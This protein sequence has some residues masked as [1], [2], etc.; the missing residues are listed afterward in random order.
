ME[1]LQYFY[2]KKI[3]KN[4]QKNGDQT[5]HE[6][7]KEEDSKRN[8]VIN[9]F[10]IWEQM[11]LLNK[12]K[13]KLSRENDGWDVISNISKCSSD[14]RKETEKKKILICLGNNNFGQLGFQE[15]SK[16]GIVDFSTVIISKNY[17]TNHRHPRGRVK[18]RVQLGVDDAVMDDAVVDD[19]VMDETFEEAQRLGESCTRRKKYNDIARDMKRRNKSRPVFNR[20]SNNFLSKNEM[21]NNILTRLPNDFN[22]STIKRLKIDEED[23]K[24]K[25]KGSIHNLRENRLI[26]SSSGKKYR[27]ITNP[28]M[29]GRKE[30]KEKVNVQMGEEAQLQIEEEE[31]KESKR[32]DIESL[33]MKFYKERNYLIRNKYEEVK[34]VAKKKF[35]SENENDNYYKKRINQYD[36]FLKI[37]EYTDRT[38]GDAIISPS[39]HT[40]IYNTNLGNKQTH[41]S[42]SFNSNFNHSDSETKRGENYNYF[43]PKTINCGKYHSG[44]VSKNGFVCLWGLNCYGQLG[45]NPNK[46]IHTCYKKTKLKKL[47]KIENKKK[48]PKKKS[49][50][51]RRRSIF[52]FM[53]KEKTILSPYIYKLIPLK[54]F[55]YKHK[56]KDIS[57][58]AFHTLLLTY[59]GFVF[60]F[61]CNKKSQLGLPNVYD[62]KISHTSKPFLLPLVIGERG[63][64]RN[65]PRYG[66]T[67]TFFFSSNSTYAN[68]AHPIIFISCGSYN[69]AVID[70]NKE[71]WMWGWNKF[72][73]IDNSYAIEKMKKKKQNQKQKEEGEKYA[74][75]F[76]TCSGGKI[77]VDIMNMKNISEILHKGG[78]KIKQKLTS[79]KELDEKV[80][81]EKEDK[82]NR[83]NYKKRNKNVNIPRNI[84][85][86]N[87]KI[88]QVS[89]GKYHCLCLT[90]EKSVYIWGYLKKEKKKKNEN[91]SYISCCHDKEY[92]KNI[93]RITKMSCLSSL[94]ISN[95]VSSSTHTAFVSPITYIDRKSDLSKEVNDS[96]LSVVKKEKASEKYRR[97]ILLKNKNLDYLKYYSDQVKTR[98]GDNIFYVKYTDLHFLI[99]NAEHQQEKKNW[100]CEFTSSNEN[101][102]FINNALHVSNIYQ[103]T[104]NYYLSTGGG[105]GGGITA[106]GAHGCE[107]KSINFQRRETHSNMHIDKY[108]YKEHAC[109]CKDGEKMEKILQ[110]LF[111]SN[112]NNL[113][114]VYL[115]QIFQVALGKNFGIFL[116]SSPSINRILNK[117]KIDYINNI[118]SLDVLRHK[119]PERNLFIIGKS[120]FHE[121]LLPSNCKQTTLPICLHKNKLIN[122][123][124]IRNKKHNF[125]NLSKRKK[126]SDQISYNINLFNLKK[127]HERIKK[128]VIN[129]SLLYNDIDH[130]GK[131]SLMLDPGNAK[132]NSLSAYK[133]NSSNF[134]TSSSRN[135]K[136]IS[137]VQTSSDRTSS[138]SNR[139]N[140][141]SSNSNGNNNLFQ[142]N[143]TQNRNTKSVGN[144]KNYPSPQEYFSG[145]SQLGF[146]LSGEDLNEYSNGGYKNEQSNGNNPEETSKMRHFDKRSAHSENSE[147]MYSSLDRISLN[148][149]MGEEKA[150]VKKKKKPTPLLCIN[151]KGKSFLSSSNDGNLEGKNNTHNETKLGITSKDVNTYDEHCEYPSRKDET[152][153]SSLMTP[154]DEEDLSKSARTG[155]LKFPHTSRSRSGSNSNSRRSYNNIATI[156]EKNNAD[157]SILISVDS[158]EK[159]PKEKNETYTEKEVGMALKSPMERRKRSSYI[160]KKKLFR[161][162]ILQAIDNM[163]N[164]FLNGKNERRKFNKWDQAKLKFKVF[165]KRKS[166]LWNYFTYHQ[167]KRKSPFGSNL[168]ENIVNI[169]LL[170]VACGDYHSLILLEVDTIL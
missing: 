12:M 42:N 133:L 115:I 98:G 91:Y 163:N 153:G 11:P 152:S 73:Q 96:K 151:Q 44:V 61:G 63:M 38:K 95:I 49:I 22:L 18:R 72:G 102:Y 54:H 86:K 154:N 101:V 40:G 28:D 123:V 149:Q 170:D 65:N 167:I 124:L 13:K 66:R 58:G 75:K 53:E 144:P 56:V 159:V 23:K 82:Y 71:L 120:D 148:M 41:M 100:T 114:R 80:Q 107:T 7:D 110:P 62:K 24:S 37:N 15:S 168:L 21:Y 108:C 93:T 130:Q 50:M 26:S 138:N 162:I 134:R 19:A 83:R 88:L 31:R 129:C 20:H 16:I 140:S 157:R 126:Y 112:N 118:C 141:S 85:I 127:Y 150:E 165:K 33:R 30:E 94:Y 113:D 109:I 169:T 3:N 4:F 84:K 139:N 64:H 122:E 10:R 77:R 99:N 142:F 43:N 132:N 39:I 106:A 78:E 70:A 90:E 89:I 2:V 87:K 46:S 146:C 136:S 74:K 51:S 32:K 52:S 137:Y 47:K 155:D 111:L 27:S 135:K 29:N 97:N 45:V 145:N 68:I 116:T 131:F 9:K 147:K 25:G 79:K 60:T 57:L 17:S 14:D 104:N 161:N 69:S 76:R 35:F 156:D 128:S 1:D 59:D 160:N 6:E 164:D 48:N 81:E 103:H 117:K 67:N 158:S 92:Y 119:I 121:I 36:E 34:M 5:K 8:D 55:G 125:L 166:C 143:L 105:A